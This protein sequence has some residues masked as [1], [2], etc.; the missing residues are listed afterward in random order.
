MWR[1]GA[2]DAGIRDRFGFVDGFRLESPF[3]D[4]L[5]QK[6]LYQIYILEHIV[7]RICA[8]LLKNLTTTCY[9]E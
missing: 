3:P 7:V 9:A 6:A 1:Y 5:P 8:K 4:F 2:V